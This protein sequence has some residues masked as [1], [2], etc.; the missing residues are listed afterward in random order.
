M[1]KEIIQL[2]FDDLYKDKRKLEIIKK[3]NF[4]QLRKYYI[5]TQEQETEIKVIDYLSEKLEDYFPK[6]YCTHHNCC[7]MEYYK[8]I[9]VFNLLVFLDAYSVISKKNQLN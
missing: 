6:I 1:N 7:D 5:C 3:E 2:F 4:V 8:G 9:R